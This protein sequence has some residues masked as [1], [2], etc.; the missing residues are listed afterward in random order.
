MNELLRKI[1]V[2]FEERKVQTTANIINNKHTH[3][4]T[5]MRII[6]NNENGSDDDFD[7]KKKTKNMFKKIYC[8]LQLKTIN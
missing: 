2:A 5:A 6:A 7:W 1:P 3:A 8:C 4:P